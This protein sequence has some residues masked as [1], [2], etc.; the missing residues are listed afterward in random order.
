MAGFMIAATFVLVIFAAV[1]LFAAWIDRDA[2]RR[3]RGN[4]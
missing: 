2:D 4:S 3:D 1:V